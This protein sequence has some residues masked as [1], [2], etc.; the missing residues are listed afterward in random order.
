VVELETGQLGVMLERGGTVP[1]PGR[2]GD[3]ELDGV[4]LVGA[5]RVLLGVS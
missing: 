2:L 1:G 4:D 5:G 3:P